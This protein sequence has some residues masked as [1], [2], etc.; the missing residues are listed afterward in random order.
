MSI[1]TVGWV[2]AT[3]PAVTADRDSTNIVGA[4]DVQAIGAPYQPH[5]FTFNGDG[6]METTNPTNVQENPSAP[7]GGSNDSLGMGPWQQVAGKPGTYIGTFYQLN[8]NADDHTPTDTL[9][10]TYKITVHGDNF[11]G[12]A[13]AKLGNLSAPAQLEGHRLKI[14]KAAINDL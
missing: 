12:K 11:S 8:A 9:K 5:L 2:V 6:T 1:L 4:W 3:G 10:V 13:I 7:H 14:D